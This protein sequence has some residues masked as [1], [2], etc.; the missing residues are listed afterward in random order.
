[1]KLDKNK[2]K[3]KKKYLKPNLILY[4]NI[5]ELTKGTGSGAP[6]GGSGRQGLGDIGR[7][8]RDTPGG[9]P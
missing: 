7:D 1:M 9:R 3:A 8:R 2:D 6:D 4:G 5:A